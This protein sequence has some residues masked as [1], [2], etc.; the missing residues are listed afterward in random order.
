MRLVKRLAC[1]S[2]KMTLARIKNSDA[3][4]KNAHAKYERIVEK[5]FQAKVNLRERVALLQSSLQTKKDCITQSE[6]NDD[7][8][9]AV[10][11]DVV[12]DQLET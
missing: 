11:C 10:D 9:V 6:K 3:L 1:D 4:F 5:A 7:S 8:E 2:L 12:A